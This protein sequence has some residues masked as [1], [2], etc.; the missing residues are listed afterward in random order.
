VGTR[1][2]DK[3]KIKKTERK[4]EKTIKKTGIKKQL[5]IV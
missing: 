3:K 2:V 5:K 4:V 1:Q